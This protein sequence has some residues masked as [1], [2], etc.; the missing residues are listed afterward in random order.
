MHTNVHDLVVNHDYTPR[1]PAEPRVDSPGEH[2]H[3][4]CRR[5]ARALA[6]KGHARGCHRGSRMWFKLHACAEVRA[7]AAGSDAR[8]RGVGARLRAEQLGVDVLDRH[9]QVLPRVFQPH[10]IAGLHHVHEL[11]SLQSGR[12]VFFVDSHRRRRHGGR[13]TPRHPSGTLRNSG[14]GGF[15]CH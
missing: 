15:V 9:R 7:A 13:R 5:S 10:V 8:R 11:G 2:T 3:A 6:K 1:R 12:G 4:R 14:A